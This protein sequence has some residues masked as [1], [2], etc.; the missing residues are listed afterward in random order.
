[1]RTELYIGGEWRPGSSGDSIEVARPGNRPAGGHGRLGL[2]RR[3]RGRGDGRRLRPARLGCPTA[4]RPLRDP[5]RVLAADPPHVDELAELIV[6]EHGKP[7]A[8][9]KGEVDYAAEFFRWN[10]EETV[11]IRGELAVAPSGA[12]RILVHHPP[13]GVVVMITPWNFPAAMI[14]RKL[15]PALGAGNGVVIKP[16]AADAAHRPPSRRAAER[17]GRARRRGQRGAHQAVGRLVRR[18]RRP[19]G[20]PH[21]VVHRLHAR[22]A[23]CC[24]AGPPTG[25]SR[26]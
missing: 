15:A 16:A 21:G 10:A 23:G 22:S 19:P 26:R 6:S 8:D 14:T 5:A 1:M 7:L 4:A 12:N 20:G 17:S 3:C 2:A 13:V 9:A 11:R 24:C 18:R 25:S